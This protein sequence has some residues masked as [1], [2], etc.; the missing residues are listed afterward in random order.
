MCYQGHYPI[1]CVD[2][3]PVEMHG[4]AITHPDAA[5]QKDGIFTRGVLLDIT[6]VRGVEWLEPDGCRWMHQREIAVY[7]GDCVDAI[8]NPYSHR[9]FAYFH[10]IALF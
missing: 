8:P 5:A 6:A 3:I 4:F 9:W 2:S 10:A 1:G 7:S